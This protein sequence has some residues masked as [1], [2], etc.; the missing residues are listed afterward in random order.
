MP[1]RGERTGKP[2]VLT[3]SFD[4]SYAGMEQG[5]GATMDQRVAHR[6]AAHKG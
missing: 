1:E 4:A 5:W 3:R 6:V 2:S